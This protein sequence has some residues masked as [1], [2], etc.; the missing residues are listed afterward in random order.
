MSIDI[1]TGQ[2][3]RHERDLF[4]IQ[5]RAE[6]VLLYGG[7]AKHSGRNETRRHQFRETDWRWSFHLVSLSRVITMF[8]TSAIQMLPRIPASVNAKALRSQFDLFPTCFTSAL[9]W[10]TRSLY[11]VTA[12]LRWAARV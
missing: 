11:F 6:I 12:S 8:R 5:N 2:A 4:R 9:Y 10:L 7:S 3:G 1:L